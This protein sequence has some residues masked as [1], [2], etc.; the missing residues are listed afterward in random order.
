[1]AIG[2]PPKRSQLSVLL[3]IRLHFV[4]CRNADSHTQRSPVQSPRL[5]GA[6]FLEH[7]SVA[8]SWRVAYRSSIYPASRDIRAK[9]AFS[10]IYSTLSSKATSPGLAHTAGDAARQSRV[11]ACKAILSIRPASCSGAFLIFITRVLCALI[12]VRDS[13]GGNTIDR[14]PRADPLQ[15]RLLARHLRHLGAVARGVRGQERGGAM[16]GVRLAREIAANRLHQPAGPAPDRRR[17]P[18]DRRPAARR[19][20]RGAVRRG[21]ARATAPACCRSARRWSARCITRSATRA[22]HTEH[23][24]CSRC[25]LAYIGFGG[26]PIGRALR[27]RVAWY[28]D[29]DL[30][31]H[32]A[33][34][35][36]SGAVDVTVS[37][38]EAIAYDMQ[39]GPQGDCARG[40]K[41]GPA[42][43]R[44]GPARRAAGTRRQPPSRALPEP[45]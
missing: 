36:A 7:P 41:I 23:H 10:S 1:M 43:D 22:H 33:R 37:W 12:G 14:Q 9:A 3:L 21:H 15:P 11:H 5:A 13:R 40:R 34:V 25:R 42:H 6:R 19:R 39:R 24:R 16:A 28:G 4:P 35:L 38:G 2:G 27:E 26:V 18:R 45:A 32:L 8:A 30:M 31:P 29:A 17:H 44:G 20:R